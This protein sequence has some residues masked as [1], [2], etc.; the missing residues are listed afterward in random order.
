MALLALVAAC[1]GK[2]A[3][4][5]PSVSPTATAAPV[6]TSASVPT[7]SPA[8]VQRPGGVTQTSQ[9]P[10]PAPPSLEEVLD[11]VDRLLE[12]GSLKSP[13]F[14][15]SPLGDLELPDLDLDIPAGAVSGLDADFDWQFE[16][17]EVD[18]EPPA[19][20]AQDLVP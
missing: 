8:P 19:V 1:G 18:I 14:I 13:D 16:V 6:P 2:D 7:A 4:P 11:E 17:P 20:S 5:T 3:T 10:T 12:S 15:E 9:P